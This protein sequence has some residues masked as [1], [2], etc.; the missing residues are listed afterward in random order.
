MDSPESLLLLG[1]RRVGKTTILRQIQAKLELKNKANFFLN[2]EDP[3]YL[4]L[5][6]ESPKNLLKIISP[7]LRK[8]N[9]VFIDEVQYLKNPSNFLKYFYDEYSGK[10]KLIVAGSSAFY[11]DQKFTDSLAGRKK[12]FIFDHSILKS[13]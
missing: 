1:G 2:L 7:N 12:Y 8:L 4:K 10:I 3:D 13:F 11:I 6:N 9:Y 5:L